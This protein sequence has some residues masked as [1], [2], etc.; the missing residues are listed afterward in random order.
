[1]A[2]DGRQKARLDRDAK[3]VGDPIVSFS[4]MGA[5]SRVVENDTHAYGDRDVHHSSCHCPDLTH[6]R[7][8]DL[9]TDG[10]SNHTFG[11]QEIQR[12]TIPNG[13]RRARL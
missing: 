8:G 13:Y 12:A 3:E 5:T 7:E 2:K 4:R 6:K 11:Q 1:M 10:C 9:L